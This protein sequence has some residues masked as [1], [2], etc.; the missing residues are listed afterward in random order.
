MEE[1]KD[2]RKRIFMA[3]ASIA[4]V[5]AALAVFFLTRPSVAIL[6]PEYP[7]GYDLI[8]PAILTSAYRTVSRAEGADVVI[9][10]PGAELPEG[11]DGVVIGSDELSIDESN[12]WKAALGEG[13]ECILY[14]SSDS[15]ARSIAE[16]LLASDDNAYAV[17]YDG[18][19]SVENMN[20]ILSEVSGSDSLLM[21]TPSTSVRLIRE[22]DAETSVVMDYRDAAAMDTTIVNEAVCIDWDAL[23]RSVLS[24]SA[25]LSYTLVTLH[26]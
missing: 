6:E 12:M 3:L 26:E 13:R 10:L 9:A 20:R 4:S 15:V 21:L 23:I 24:D 16:G 2:V 25:E 5:L 22:N 11:T 1:E 14:E 19:I 7:A 8:S 18:R 17:T